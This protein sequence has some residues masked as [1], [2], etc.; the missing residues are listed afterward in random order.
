PSHLKFQF[1]P[2]SRDHSAINQTIT[3][4]TAKIVF[5]DTHNFIPQSDLPTLVD[6]NNPKASKHV[7]IY[8]NSNGAIDRIDVTSAK[9]YSPQHY[10]GRGYTQTTWIDLY[11]KVQI[12]LKKE[13]KYPE[14]LE[15]YP[16]I[17]DLVNHPEVAN[18]PEVSYLIM[19]MVMRNGD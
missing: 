5:Q 2:D 1:L 6:V 3:L 17:K 14:L 12:N 16:N 7:A 11:Q 9:A 15:K 18:T 19:S 4:T 8:E 13:K 10:F